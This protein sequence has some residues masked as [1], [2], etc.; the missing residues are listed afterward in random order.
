MICWPASQSS[1][2]WL[3]YHM[4]WGFDPALRLSLAQSIDRMTTDGPYTD[5][6]RK[7]VVSWTFMEQR[8]VWKSTLGAENIFGLFLICLP[9]CPWTHI[10]QEP[11]RLA[12]E[13][14]SLAFNIFSSMTAV[15]P[16]IRKPSISYRK[17]QISN[18]EFHKPL[19]NCAFLLRKWR[20]VTVPAPIISRVVPRFFKNLFPPVLVKPFL[21][22]AVSDCYAPSI[23][24]KFS[25]PDFKWFLEL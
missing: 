14:L 9:S 16:L 12:I 8:S 17:H 21:C 18:C 5:A 3:E 4:G 10:T 15:F 25:W 24:R 19:N 11:G 6:L 13:L 2:H 7:V 20:H 23:E 22:V 1:W